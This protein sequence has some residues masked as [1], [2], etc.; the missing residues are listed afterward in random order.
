VSR[1]QENTMHWLL[2][3]L[4]GS[5]EAKEQ[6]FA[7]CLPRVRKIVALRLGIPSANLPAHAEDVVQETLLSALRA[8]PRFRP[9]SGGE[10]YA[11][12]AK[13]A[14]NRVRNEARRVRSRR[15]LPAT[16]PAQDLMLSEA[17]FPSQDRTPSSHAANREQEMR[18]ESAI[19]SMPWLYRSA[20]ELHDIA[21]MDYQEVA[22]ELGRS[23]S[24]CRKIYQRARE[25]LLLRLQR[26]DPNG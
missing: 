23:E 4:Q 1:N 12:L 13:I 16:P 10:F 15:E 21:G 18:V 14:E 17:L 19:S 6:L 20:I 25:M 8:L 26:V 24:N 2:A 3:S 7:R 5:V 11:W 22:K 9:R